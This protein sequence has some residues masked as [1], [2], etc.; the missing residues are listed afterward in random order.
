MRRCAHSMR[1]GAHTDIHIYTHTQST[2]AH[3]AGVRIQR[4]IIY[5]QTKSTRACAGVHIEIHMTENWKTNNRELSLTY[6]GVSDNRGGAKDGAEQARK[7]IIQ[8][9]TLSDEVELVACGGQQAE[10]GGGC[11]VA[12]TLQPRQYERNYHRQHQ[13]SIERHTVLEWRFSDYR[14][15]PRG[16]DPQRVFVVDESVTAPI[17]PCAHLLVPK[18][19]AKIVPKRVQKTIAPLLKMGMEYFAPSQ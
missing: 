11:E 10:L 4:F 12:H 6:L 8:Q 2:R 7:G 3:A 9:T 17:G 13:R 14:C 16:S 5:K 15:Q 18:H 1:R 19:R